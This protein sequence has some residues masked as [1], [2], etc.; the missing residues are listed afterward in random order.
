MVDRLSP[1]DVSFLYLEEPTT[2]M[3][4]GG[5][6]LFQAPESGFD[7]DR[8]TR[9]IE[10]RI[11]LVPRYRQ[12]VKWVP[13]RIANP[14]WIDDEDFDVHFHVRRSALPKPGSDDQLKEL[15]ARIMSRPLDRN[16]PLWE[17]YLVEGL[18]DGRFAILSKTHHAMVD[19][20]GALDI[21]QVILDLTPQPRVVEA[22]P[23]NPRPEP[24]DADLVSDALSEMVRSP[25]VA[26]DAVRTGADDMRETAERF[27][28]RAA[29]LAAAALTMARPPSHNPLNRPIGEARRYGMADARLADL[30]AIRKTHGGTINDVVLTVVAGALREWMQTRGESVTAMTQV[31]ALVPTS[32]R[33]GDEGSGNHIAA[34]LVDLPV[35]EPRAVVRLH[36]VSFEMDQ[37]KSTGQ[38]VGAQA[39]VGVAG[40]APPTLHSLGARAAS[41]LSRRMFNLVVTNVPGPQLP[42]YADGALMLAAHPVV[43]LAKG[44][45]LSVGVTSYNG[46]MFFGLN[47]D[48]DGMADVDVLAECINT[49]ID[50]LLDTVPDDVRAAVGATSRSTEQRAELAVLVSPETTTE[51]AHVPDP[52]EAIE[53][54]E[55]D[56][57]VDILD[58]SDD[59]HISHDDPVVNDVAHESVAEVAPIDSDLVDSDLAVADLVETAAPVGTLAPAE[60]V[61]SVDSSP[62]SSTKKKKKKSKTKSKDKAKA[63]KSDSPAPVV[64]AVQP[65]GVAADHGDSITAAPAGV[66]PVRPRQVQSAASRG[67]VGRGSTELRTNPVIRGSSLEP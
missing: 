55:L 4:V 8:L 18:S 35:G 34:F 60:T 22:Q 43:P 10:T 26:F 39:L 59:S 6:V 54:A 3:H 2:P 61:A 11:G 40:F 45:A 52:V 27:G 66:V 42:L 21:G 9:L 12:K 13:G 29:G 20:A 64:D 46:G 25:A 15:V 62:S 67:L 28:R 57:S 5:V 1:L 58:L 7:L 50:E 48:R 33:D 31:R 23:W 56:E 38:M 49:A 17:M 36:R 44:Q 53:L 65:L 32:V 47:A 16:R 24:S 19:G 41:D 37:L 63:N 14:V 51:P 30:K